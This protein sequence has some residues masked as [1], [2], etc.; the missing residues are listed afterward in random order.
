MAIVRRSHPEARLIVA[1]EGPER[2]ELEHR[3]EE[4][5]LSGE[6]LFPGHVDGVPGL[7]TAADV[8]VNPA[9]AEAF[10]YAVLEAMSL[11]RPSVVTDAGG[12]AEAIEDG[13]SGIVV[14]VRDP[15]ALAA[16]I[17]TL[18]S[19]P[20]LARRYGEAAKD[21]ALQRFTRRQMV[22]GTLAT[23]GEVGVA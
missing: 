4:L 19:D 14:G 10:P 18:L 1:G 13:R 9:W 20:A 11:G 22:E 12:T 6:V 15:G 16:G 21:R 8:F 3:R 23:Y 7:L 5:G 17:E 2:A